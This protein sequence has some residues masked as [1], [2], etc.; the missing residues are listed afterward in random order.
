MIK[1]PS[2]VKVIR[3]IDRDTAKI[4]VDPDLMQRVLHNLILN[5]IQAM[6]EGGKLI[7]KASKIT[8]MIQISVQD[9]GVGIPSENLDKLWHALQTTKAKGVGLGLPV[10]KRLVEAHNGKIL[11]ESE[12]GKGSTFTIKLPL[13][14]EVN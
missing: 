1:I 3:E 13:R 2:N 9:T 4:I 6:P 5:G 14:R 12:V 8:D 7:I 11:V 10:C